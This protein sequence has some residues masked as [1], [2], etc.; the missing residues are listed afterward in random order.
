MQ[1]GMDARTSLSK[2]VS[3]LIMAIKKSSFSVRS[4][5]REVNS[6]LLPPEMPEGKLAGWEDNLRESH[7]WFEKKQDELTMVL[8]VLNE[9][10]SQINRLLKEIEEGRI[11]AGKIDVGKI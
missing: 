7:A 2:Q 9:T 1:E 5:M 3:N 10:Q 4:G 6:R 11:E 8:S